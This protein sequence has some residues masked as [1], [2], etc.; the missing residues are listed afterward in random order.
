MHPVL[1]E[2]LERAGKVANRLKLLELRET[3][4]VALRVIRG[5]RIGLASTSRLDDLGTL[6]AN[7]VELAQ[8]GPE[9][10]LELPGGT[11]YPE[12]PVYDPAVEALPVEALVELG[13]RAIDRIR[14]ANSELVCSAHL[15]KGLNT[16][17][18][19]NTRGAHVTYTKSGFGVFLE[20]TLVQGTDML[21]IWEG[22]ASCSAD[23]QM[24][25][26]VGSVLRQLEL[27]RAVAPAPAGEVPVLFAPRG[28]AGVLLTPLLAGFNGRTVYQKASPLVDRLGQQVLGPQFSLYDDPTLAYAAGA[29]MCDDEGVPTRRTPLVE[30]GVVRSFLYDLQTAA[31]MGVESTGSAHRSLS[32][33]PS[34]GAS[35][36]VIPPGDTP[37]DDLLAGMERGLVVER[38]LG[39][40]QSNILGGDFNANVLLGYAVEGGRI[41]G[42]VKDTL[43]AGNVYKVLSAIEGMSRETRWVGGFAHVPAILCRGVSVATQA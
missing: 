32:T 23:T 39:A 18:I 36:V 15:S 17:A 14:R 5:G 10:R 6:V 13:Q 22:K 26:M 16:V 35:V 29:R 24:D 37:Y 25:D 40:G 8:F 1:E 31:E 27:A 30:G 4:G 3:T 34:P 43:I 33:M 2:V 21:F 38:L 7:A 28:V 20:A 19:A 12:V 11:T 41:V 9:A 42:R